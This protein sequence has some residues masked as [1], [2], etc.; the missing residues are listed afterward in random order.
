[1]DTGSTGVV[2]G[3]RQL[4]LTVEQLQHYPKGSEF[5]SS[6]NVLW[7]GHWINASDANFTFSGADVT[8]KVPILA[9]TESSICG[10]FTDG[11]CKEG[12]RTACVGMPEGINYLGQ[13]HTPVHTLVFF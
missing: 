6:S 13:P 8:A 4:D 7:E 11:K 3:A 1:M 10:T 12:T 9:V 5:L 2:I